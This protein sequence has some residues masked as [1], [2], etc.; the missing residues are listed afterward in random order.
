[1][2]LS[3]SLFAQDS[4]K[5]LTQD[6]FELETDEGIKLRYNKCMLV[7]FHGND[8]ESL[9]LHQVWYSAA[10]QVV[11]PSFGSINLSSNKMLSQAFVGLN[12]YNSPLRWAALKT[13]PF[14][15][16]YQNKWP[17]AFYNGERS[18]QAIINYSLTLACKAEY[19]EPVNLYGGMTANNNLK[20]ANLMKYG[21]EQNPI[22]TS[23]IQ[24]TSDNIRGYTNKV[25]DNNKVI[26]NNNNNNKKV[27]NEELIE[28]P[29]LVSD[30]V[31]VASPTER[32]ISQIEIDV[33]NLVS[34]FRPVVPTRNQTELIRTEPLTETPTKPPNNYRT[35]NGRPI[36][37]PSI[38]IITRS[39]INNAKINNTRIN[40]TRINN[41]QAPMI[42][43][44]GISDL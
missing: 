2:A 29:E 31:R 34:D 37:L 12:T 33:N 7:L 23:S 17:I 22:K 32:G 36:A 30:G 20:I 39:R 44:R 42:P 16:V 41:T 25:V 5:E 8:T 9:D 4:I 28:L 6:D 43:S 18:V 21:T 40:N 27:N 3:E 10:Q 11:G 38:H 14:I 13:V 24:Y 19:N 15:M 35:R 26:N 1:M